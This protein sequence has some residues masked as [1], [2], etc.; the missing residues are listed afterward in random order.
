MCGQLLRIRALR[1]MAYHLLETGKRISSRVVLVFFSHSFHVAAT[2]RSVVDI[3]LKLPFI[4]S[5][6]YLCESLVPFAPCSLGQVLPL[7]TLRNKY[8]IAAFL[9]TKVNH[10]CFQSL[11]IL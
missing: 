5:R 8:P 9:S 6:S 10:N 2:V 4:I 3:I 11:I 7:L 1:H